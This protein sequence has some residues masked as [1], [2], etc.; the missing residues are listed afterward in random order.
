MIAA[1]AERWLARHD[2]GLS[3]AETEAFVRWRAESAAHAAEFD[4]LSATWENAEFL[5]TNP[6]L[7]ALAARLEA[8]AMGK[9]AARRRRRFLLG[10]SAGLAAAAAVAFAFLR[11]GR[12]TGVPDSAIV[13]D[14]VATVRIRPADARQVTLPDGS[15]VVLRGDSE[16][17]PEFTAGARR[18]QLLRGEAYFLVRK[19]ATRPFF[20]E[21]QGAAVTAVG[22]AFTVQLSSRALEVLVT[23]GTVAFREADAAG[24]G[25]GA[26][27]SEA[28]R[29]GAG[30][31]GRWPVSGG[32]VTDAAVTVTPVSSAEIEQALSWQFAEFT[33]RRATLA[34]AIEA[35]NTHAGTRFEIADAS[36]QLRQISGTFTAK[37]ADAF[38]RLLEQ[39]AEVRA[40]R[41]A[42]G[43][44]RLHAATP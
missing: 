10:W 40:E 6:E 38:V 2:R 15:T 3:P 37:Q 25:V 28:P 23:E 1:E 24:Q 41:G 26:A 43:R 22:T 13:S 16:V 30:Q 5:Q 4:R 32:R 33:F 20:V 42:D 36:L 21:T 35:F 19:D 34:E 44:V 17:R 8:T 7:R 18:V 29:A 39:A 14:S 27:V 11:P 31:R 9:A 12:A